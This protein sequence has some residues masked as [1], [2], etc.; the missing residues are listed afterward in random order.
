MPSRRE[1]SSQWM[2]TGECQYQS[3]RGAVRA[4]QAVST[5]TTT[6]DTVERAMT[7]SRF[8]EGLRSPFV[9]LGALS[10]DLDAVGE[11]AA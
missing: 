7:T 8:T 9:L 5:V 6:T 4:E 1:C 3:L 10:P 11:G 2:L